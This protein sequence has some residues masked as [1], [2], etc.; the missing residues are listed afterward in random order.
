[1]TRTF[2]LLLSALL[3]LASLALS[4]AAAPAPVASDAKP[5]ILR[6]ITIDQKLGQ[7]IPDDL[8]FNDESGKPVTLGQLRTG[9]PVVLVLVYFGCPSLCTVVLNDTLS[10]L[11]IMPLTLGKDYDVWTV[12]FD[13]RETAALARAK[14]AEYVHTYDHTKGFPLDAPLTVDNWH[15]LTGDQANIARLTN[16][17]GFRY[18]WDEQSKQFYHPA[19]LTILSP[20]L[21]ISRYFFGVRYEMTDIRLGLLDAGRGK[22]GSLTDTILLFCYHY[23]PSTGRYSLAITNILKAFAA[24]TVLVIGGALAYLFHLDRRRTRALLTR[25]PPAARPAPAGRGGMPYG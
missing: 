22:I 13:P 18:K 4:A 3:L 2:S 10:T 7:K 21:T 24:V 11:S 15:F 12:S 23:D 17:V 8:T 25:I 9:R 14:K 5:A 1:M 20:D 6:D 16:A 19:G